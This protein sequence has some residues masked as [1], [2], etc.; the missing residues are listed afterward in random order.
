MSDS[1]LG[2]QGAIEEYYTGNRV[3]AGLLGLVAYEYV[4][5]FGQEVACVW[6]KPISATSVLLLSTRWVMVLYQAIWV[7]PSGVESCRRWEPVSQ[8]LLFTSWAQIAVFSGLRVY[9]L[10]HDS[11]LRHVLLVAVIL[12]GCI[13]IA[14]NSFA[15]SRMQTMYT[16]LPFASCVYRVDVPK[17]LSTIA[18]LHAQWRTRLRPAGGHPHVDEDIYALEAAAAGG[19]EVVRRDLTPSGWYHIFCNHP[20]SR[21]RTDGDVLC[22]QR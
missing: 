6:Q 3:Q 22:E 17:H 16:D 15:W 21:C 14:T 11:R 1:V 8:L 5:T 19:A 13:P 10:W 20:C 18:L 9:A 12:L 7:T 2:E 4:I